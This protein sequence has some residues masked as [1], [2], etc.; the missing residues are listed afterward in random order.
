MTVGMMAMTSKGLATGKDDRYLS[1]EVFTFP[2]G[3]HH[4][5]N[6]PEFDEPVT[7][8]A[9]VRGADPNDLVQAALLADVAHYRGDDFNL[10]LPYVPAARADRGTPFGL[11]VYA[12]LINAMSASKVL[13]LD[14]HSPAA[15]R[16]IPG[17]V[18]VDHTE[19]VER[20]V[21]TSLHPHYDAVIAPDEGARDRAAAVAARLGVDVYQAEKKRDFD[22]G[23]ILG[24]R[25]TEPF[26]P[27]GRYLVVDD[28]CDGGGTFLGLADAL[29]LP[30][31]QLGLWV[32]HGIFSGN[33]PKLRHCFGQILTTDSHAGCRR[34][35]VASS[36]LPAFTYLIQ[37]VNSPE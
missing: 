35:G 8:V 12:R 2:G 3:E 25:M 36:I 18:Q 19:I 22:T 21:K 13:V 30:V 1:P 16:C 20:A 9:V 32:T 29:D 23:E 24:I 10:L 34:L 31:E 33:A 11:Y 6:I 15:A 28:I 17:L 37:H 5:R 14:P 26:P 7:W 4:L 27:S